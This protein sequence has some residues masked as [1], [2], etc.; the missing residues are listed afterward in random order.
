MTTPAVTVL[1]PVYN[2]ERFVAGTV[3]TILA[4]TFGYFEFLIINDGSTD[5]SLEIL[6]S[7]ANRDPRIRLVSRPG[8]SELPS[9]KLISGE[10]NGAPV[11]RTCGICTLIG[12][13]AVRIRCGSYPLRNPRCPS[14]RRW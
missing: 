3:D 8:T 10:W 1:M 11:P 7:Y 13:S 6:Q 4:Q 2:A 9:R 5:R 12:P 14:S